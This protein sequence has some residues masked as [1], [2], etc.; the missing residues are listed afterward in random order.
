LFTLIEDRTARSSFDRESR[1]PVALSASPKP[2]SSG[3][4][5]S[6]AKAGTSLWLR[7]T[8]DEDCPCARAAGAI[9]DRAALHAA[10]EKERSALGVVLSLGK[11]T[12]LDGRI[13]V[14]RAAAGEELFNRAWADGEGLSI[15]AVVRRTLD[16]AAS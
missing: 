9:T 10:A 4:D 7:N 3:I 16:E 12:R 15:D 5:T 8:L 1:R 11:C 6:I 13:A 2:A 14:T